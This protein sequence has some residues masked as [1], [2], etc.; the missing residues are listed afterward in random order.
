MVPVSERGYVRDE[1]E[2]SAM[3]SIRIGELANE[4]W[5][6]KVTPRTSARCPV[7]LAFDSCRVIAERAVENGGHLWALLVNGLGFFRFASTWMH[8]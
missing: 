3:G 1:R 2:L 4:K 7:H 8:A 6:T 5:Q